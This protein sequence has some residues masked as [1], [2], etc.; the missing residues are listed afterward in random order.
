MQALKWFL[1]GSKILK[2]FGIEILDTYDLVSL[3]FL[4]WM[5]GYS[6]WP[7]FFVILPVY[8]LSHFVAVFLMSFFRTLI[9]G[10][11]HLD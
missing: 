3:P 4:I 7:F 11:G 5:L 8:L 9:F 10:P 1:R 2:V 6:G